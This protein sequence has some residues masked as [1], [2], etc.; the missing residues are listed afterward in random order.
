MKRLNPETGEPFNRGDVREDGFIFRTY[1]K[2]KLT[3]GFFREAWLSPEAYKKARSDQ[4]GHGRD[5]R[6]IR[7]KQRRKLIDRIKTTSG[8]ELCGYNKHPQAL[9]FDHIDRANKTASIS[10]ISLFA[11][12]DSL[13]LE[14]DKCRVL[15]ANCHRVHTH[16]N[17]H[18]RRLKK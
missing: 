8:C 12:I 4:Q 5:W 13:M 7:Q 1:I 16:K 9:D 2:T 18:F 17:K 3:N 14:I 6:I 11:N 15:C 10:K